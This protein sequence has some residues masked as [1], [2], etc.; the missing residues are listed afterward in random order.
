MRGGAKEVRSEGQEEHE[1]RRRGGEEERRR[2]SLS[3]SHP[4]PPPTQL[5][6]ND[7]SIAIKPVFEKFQS[8]VITSGTLSPIDMYPKILGFE[9]C[10]VHSFAM[11]YSRNIIRCALFI[12]LSAGPLGVPARGSCMLL[13]IA[14]PLGSHHPWDLATLGISPPLGSRHPCKRVSRVP[15]RTAGTP[16]LPPH[17]RPTQPT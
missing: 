12:A 2:E 5:C 8:V 11:S 16:H 9:P 17:A 10:A 7:A 13:R 4:H 1:Q 3:P 15:S 14:P 6:C